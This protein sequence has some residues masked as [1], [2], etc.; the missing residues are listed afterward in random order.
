VSVSES[1][2]RDMMKMNGIELSD[3]AI[4]HTTVNKP[5]LN[6]LLDDPSS[7]HFDVIQQRK[8]CLT[9]QAAELSLSCQMCFR[10]GENL[11]RYADADGRTRGGF[12]DVQVLSRVNER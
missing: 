10:A 4:G 8:H 11:F 2:N 7:N 1:V 6:S 5:S 12:C 9:G 3:C